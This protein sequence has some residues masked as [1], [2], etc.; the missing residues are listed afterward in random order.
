[1]TTTDGDSKS[2]RAPPNAVQPGGA[3]EMDI[4]D[5]YRAVARR[6]RLLLPLLALTMS[7]AG[8]YVLVTPAR[9]AASMSFL[10]DTRERPPVGVDAQPI[11]QNPD[12]G[13]I[14]S[15]M[16]L[17]TSNEVLR[18]TINNEQLGSDP[19]FAPV[20]PSGLFATVKSLLGIAPPKPDASIDRIVEAL[21]K[22]IT[23]KRSEKSYVVDVEVRASS[24]EK[25]ERL[26]RGL[27][28]AYYETQSKLGDDI[29]DK[30]TDWLDKKLAE[31]RG[32]LEKAE[33]RIEDYRKSQSILITDGHTLPEQQIKDANSALVEAR[34]KRAEMEAK[35]AQLQAAI[36]GGGSIET[37]NEAIHSPLIEKLRGDYSALSRDSAYA[38]STLGP[39]HP[40]FTIVKAQIA[41]LRA[42][43]TAELR[44]VAIAQDHDL[45]A[46]RAAE[47]AAE[48]LVADLQKSINDLGGRRME[49][50][51]LERQAAALR[52]RY[53]K[54]LSAR[55]NVHREIVSSPNGVLIDQ[56]IAQKARVSPRLLPALLI[57]IAAGLNIWVAA[58]L[59][60]EFRER[61]RGGL[62][63]KPLEAADGVIPIME[64]V[65]AKS[66]DDINSPPQGSALDRWRFGHSGEP[67]APTIISIPTFDTQLGPFSRLAR[68]DAGVISNTRAAMTTPGAPYREAV[69][70][71]YDLIWSSEASTGAAPVVAMATSARGAGVSTSALSMAL[72]ACSLGDLVLLMDC[73][74]L[75]PTLASLL[76]GLE[77]SRHK[78]DFDHRLFVYRRDA[79][80]GGEILLSRLNGDHYRWPSEEYFK[81]RLDL[82]ILDCGEIVADRPVLAPPQEIDAVIMIERDVHG[83][84]NA[85]LLLSNN[86]KAGD[87]LRAPLRHIPAHASIG[88]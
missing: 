77:P 52:D 35:F 28:N 69:A 7:L 45:R 23:T 15:Q 70:D 63:D 14:E 16:R 42:Q 65:R 82:I 5:L 8:L 85:C 34:G 62:V 18:R 49:L 40:S 12:T 78:F 9:Y 80:S 48:Q 46:A 47:R 67:I 73:N 43:I 58:A 51:E 83:E 84:R 19:E 17:L 21:G 39:R 71:L 20:K 22:A 29:A 64:E 68:G 41:S 1:M 3:T 54:T 66:T 56:P 53:E 79:A 55:E 57:A 60:M 88:A 59:V 76:P 24:P 75:H 86:A 50:N 32:R 38:E 4:G 87:P 26:A 31:L 74:P 13:L 81:S 30:E 44:R 37:L 10:V 33:Q 25:A 11:A 2:E 36:R 72:F 27:A 61:K 6:W